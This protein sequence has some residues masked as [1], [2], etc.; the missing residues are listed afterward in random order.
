[1]V[2]AESIAK[3]AFSLPVNG[4]SDVVESEYG[5]HLIKVTERKGGERPSDFEK[6]KDYVRDLCTQEMQ[7]GLLDELRK[8]AKVEINLPK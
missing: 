8:A 7:L 5:L 3:V 2:M 4:V 1:M 6:I